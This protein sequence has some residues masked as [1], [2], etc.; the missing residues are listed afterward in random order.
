[1]SAS[2]RELFLVACTLKQVDPC[3]GDGLAAIIH[4][5]PAQGLERLLRIL[6]ATLL[7]PHGLQLA[8]REGECPADRYLPIGRHRCVIQQRNQ[9]NLFGFL[10]LLKIAC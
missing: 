5:A 4:H 3:I 6:Q 7:A 2:V 1:V 9:I 8:I 10:H